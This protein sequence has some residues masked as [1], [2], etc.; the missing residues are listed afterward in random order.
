MRRFFL[1]LLYIKDNPF[2]YEDV[3]MENLVKYICKCVLLHINR[4]LCF[5]GFF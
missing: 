4:I 1:R 2:R 5:I 3:F